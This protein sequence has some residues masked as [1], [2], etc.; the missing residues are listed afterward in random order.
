MRVA[1]L[2]RKQQQEQAKQQL[3]LLKQNRKKVQN[4]IKTQQRKTTTILSKPTI[5]P[6]VGYKPITVGSSS[7]FAR[8]TIRPANVMASRQP[9]VPKLP[10]VNTTQYRYQAPQSI[11]PQL[12]AAGST[13]YVAANQIRTQAQPQVQV[14]PQAPYR[15]SP[16]TMGVPTVMLTGAPSGNVIAP[17]GFSHMCNTIK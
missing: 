15:Q 9:V 8:P 14:R 4:A 12:S 7:S 13:R 6:V 16:S 2:Q 10:T 17:T 11:Q 1:A 5:Q 3:N